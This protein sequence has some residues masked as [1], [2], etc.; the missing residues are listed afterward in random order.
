MALYRSPDYQTSL[1]P[2]DFSV[3][4]K[5]FNTDFQD[6]S[7]LEFPIRMIFATSS[8]DLNVLRNVFCILL[9]SP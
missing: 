4:E 8:L 3:Q 1:E 2:I 7:H 5:N 6:G 9:Y